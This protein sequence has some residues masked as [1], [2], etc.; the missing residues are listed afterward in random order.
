MNMNSTDE[1]RRE[2]RRKRRAR[3]QALA[4]ISLLVFIAIVIVGVLFLFNKTMNI[5]SSD[6]S[7]DVADNSKELPE[8]PETPPIVI[9]EPEPIEDDPVDEVSPEEQ[10]LNEMVNSYIEQMDLQE[11]VAGLFIITPEQLTGYDKVTVGGNATKEALEQIPIGGLIYFSKNI[12]N[13]QKFTDML[14]KTKEFSKY[15]IFLCV[16]EEGGK[17]SRV[18]NGLKECNGV[19]SP[20]VIG[21]TGEPANAYAAY[22]QVAGY[23][24]QVGIN[25][26]FAP[27]ADVR[28]A[29]NKLFD[30][31]SFG[32]DP[33]SVAEFIDGAVLGL[34]EGGISACLKHFPGHGA[35]EGDSEV[36][37]AVTNR[38]L[39][40]MR[41]SEFL[42]FISGIEQG[43][44]FI[45]VGHISAPAIT[46]DNTPSTISKKVI[47][48]ILR[49]ELGY[50]GIII[51]DAMNMKAI[52]EYYLP[53]DAAVLAFEAGAD[54]ILM[55]ENYEEAYEAMLDAVANGAISEER[56]D[57]SLRRIY[58]V[59]CKNMVATSYDEIGNE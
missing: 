12:A 39:E 20:S 19:D 30:L 38:T 23:L 27:V 6:K 46:G 17:V 1:E 3:N 28:T 42:P 41:E 34:Q 21:A 36:G 57:E 44:D 9:V 8:E 52:T 16:D 24:D 5:W 45:M 56:I 4:Y 55:P 2:Y 11:K 33:L 58:R 7:K 35:T 40:E 26:D 47:T 29:M 25:V 54:I 51:T 10:L 13:Y 31:R 48:G 50:D 32:D 59:K 14:Q 37:L 18:A 22:L 49:N 15:P 53:G 43:V